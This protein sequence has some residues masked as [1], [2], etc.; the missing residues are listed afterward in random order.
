MTD[1]VAG[2]GKGVVIEMSQA[3]IIKSSKCGINLVL[4]PELSFESLMDEILKKF[5]E[6]E[7]F[8]ANASFAISF[9]GRELSDAEKYQIVDTIMSETKVK[10][11]C[12]IENDEIRDAVIE[13]KIQAQ[14]AENMVTKRAQGAFYYGSLR[15]G[16]QLE[17]DESII[18]IGDVP[19]KASVISKSDII[20]LGTLCGSAYAG[21]DG[22]TDSFIAALE[23]LPEKYNIAGIYGPQPAKEKSTF[24]SKRNK[25]PQAKI[26]VVCDG[27]ININPLY[28]GLDNYL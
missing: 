14:Q 2:S 13:K 7:K 27:I 19:A 4:D 18:I 26:A 8:F 28:K 20:V 12:I 22:K 24:F 15:A 5:R 17:A 1:A 6:S 3:V 23:F 11:L 21:M 10:I 16:E 9:E 25:T